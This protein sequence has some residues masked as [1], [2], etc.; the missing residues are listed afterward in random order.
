M[1]IT[2]KEALETVRSKF[3]GYCL[4]RAEAIALAG[5]EINIHWQ[6]YSD[7]KGWTREW[8]TFEQALTEIQGEYKEKTEDVLI[9]QKI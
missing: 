1:T 9:E 2:L 3:Q 4:V 6:I 7:K 8:D 5:G